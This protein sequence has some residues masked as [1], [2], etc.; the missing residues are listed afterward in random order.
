MIITFN[1]IRTIP[2]P[3]GYNT[4]EF[5]AIIKNLTHPT[6]FVKR[7]TTLIWSNGKNNMF[8]TTQGLSKYHRIELVGIDE[9]EIH[10]NFH[11]K[12]S[13]LGQSVFLLSVLIST[14]SISIYT[15]FWGFFIFGLLFCIPIT[16]LLC[17]RKKSTLNWLKK[18]VEFLEKT[19]NHNSK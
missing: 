3:N 2:N 5:F 9:N 7:Y 17:N 11:I 12:I 6:G 4:Q 13:Y 19:F 1:E 14:I 15:Q 16:Y 10:L 8:R 18:E